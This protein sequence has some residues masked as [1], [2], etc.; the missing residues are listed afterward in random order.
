MTWIITRSGQ[1]FDLANPTAAMVHPADIAHSLS[2]QCR[3]NGH[4]SHFYSVAKH[5]Y[6]AADLVPAEEHF[7]GYK[8]FTTLHFFLTQNPGIAPIHNN[9]VRIDARPPVRRVIYRAP[10]TDL[11]RKLSDVRKHFKNIFSCRV[12]QR[13][14]N[15]TSQYICHLLEA[16]QIQLNSSSS[17]VIGKDDWQL[18]NCANSFINGSLGQTNETG[19][20]ASSFFL[21]S[22][23]ISLMPALRNPNSGQN[24]TNRTNRLHPCCSSGFNAKM[25]KHHKQRP[26]QSTDRN[27]PPYHPNARNFHVFR[28]VELRHVQ[29][30]LAIL[31]LAGMPFSCISTQ[32]GAA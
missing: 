31:F 8:S 15:H 29:W 6:L 16:N 23:T 30:L 18:L 4:T 26:T 9:K 17:D 21:S 2:M 12:R 13:L 14:Q 32:R 5:C 27:E 7:E 20:F 24:R 22:L 25:A 10:R 3:F 19:T 11:S 1:K 28:H